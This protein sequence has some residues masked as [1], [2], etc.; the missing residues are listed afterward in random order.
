ADSPGQTLNITYVVDRVLDKGGNVTLQAA[1]LTAPGANNPPIASITGPADSANFS[2]TNNISVTADAAD[3]DGTVARVEF[4]AGDSKL[5]E[6]TSSPFGVT[7]GKALAGDY[8]LT[9]KATD[10][11]GTTA[12]SAPVEI[13]VNGPGG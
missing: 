6:S 10:N 11:G 4:F 7:W 9:V 2:T 1:T 12:T 8:I 5:G 3:T 13:F